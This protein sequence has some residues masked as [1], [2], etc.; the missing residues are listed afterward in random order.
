MARL[1]RTGS[2]IASLCECTP[3]FKQLVAAGLIDAREATTTLSEVIA[4]L[5]LSPLSGE[6]E[7]KIRNE[8]GGVIGDGYEILA[9]SPKGN[10]DSKL[11]VADV[12]ATLVWLYDGLEA[13]IAGP[14]APERLAAIEKVLH[15]AETGLRER[16]DTEVALR[17]IG[18]LRQEIN[19]DQA[20]ERMIEFRKWPRTVAEACRRAAENLK[21]I[22]GTAGKP[23][24]D[25]YPDFK[26]V[27]TFVAEKNGIQPKIRI[28]RR[29]HEAEGRFL[30]L[31]ERFEELLPRFMRSNSRGAIA[32]MLQR[33]RT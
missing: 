26:R 33:T 9:G 21:L 22:K 12:Q 4:D 31:A 19:Y 20:R 5:G 1:P 14:L 24:R 32:K 13:M 28:N 25:W 16:H 18:T 11:T 15:G 6:D 27:L 29:T 3:A 17:L 7:Q 10:P 30:D 23:R 2:S 8:L